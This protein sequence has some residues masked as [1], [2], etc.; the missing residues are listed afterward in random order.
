MSSVQSHATPTELSNPRPSRWRLRQRGLD[1]TLLRARVSHFFICQQNPILAGCVVGISIPHRWCPSEAMRAWF[2][3]HACHV[4]YQQRQPALVSAH[5]W[6]VLAEEVNAGEIALGDAISLG[7]IF[8]K[9]SVSTTREPHQF[10]AAEA[11]TTKTISHS[12]ITFSAGRDYIRRN[13]RVLT[14]LSS[15]H[16]NYMQR[17]HG[18]ESTHKTSQGFVS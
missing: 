7:E 3:S 15:L 14:F 18:G 1:W 12:L 5:K 16:K 13:S 8:K 4:P 9:S 10:L 2:L 6:K 17:A 11:S